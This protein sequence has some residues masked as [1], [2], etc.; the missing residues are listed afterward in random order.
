MAHLLGIFSTGKYPKTK[1]IVGIDQ[2][3]PTKILISLSMAQFLHTPNICDFLR[4]SYRTE[5]LTISLKET[6]KCFYKD[7]FRKIHPY[8]PSQPTNLHFTME[9]GVK[10]G[11]ERVPKSSLL[12]IFSIF[13]GQTRP[14]PVETCC[15]QWISTEFNQIHPFI[16]SCSQIRSIMG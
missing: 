13:K 9:N 14:N 16:T 4:N 10:M 11:S 2:T 3:A 8:M 5:V 1:K 6:Q 7:K 12:P 15:S